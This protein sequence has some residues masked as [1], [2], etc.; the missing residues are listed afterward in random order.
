MLWRFY[1]IRPPGPIVD[2]LG[3]MLVLSLVVERTLSVFAWIINRIIMI[4][5]AAS[6]VT[7]P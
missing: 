7:A 1:G 2:C 5:S 6:A 3:V 4:K